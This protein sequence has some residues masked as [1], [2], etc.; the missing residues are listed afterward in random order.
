[1][2]RRRRYG[3][4]SPDV[5]ERGTRTRQQI[6]DSTLELLAKRGLHDTI[7]DD[8]AIG[9]GVSRATLYQYFESKDA[10]FLEMVDESGSELLRVVAELGVLGP[11]A[12]GYADLEGWLRSWASVYDKYATIFI[13]W[14][15][16]DVPNGQLRPRLVRFLEV[17]ISRLSERLT[18]AGVE[19][20]DPDAIAIALIAVIERCNYFRHTRR[21]PFRDDD[22]LENLAKV[23]QLVLFPDTPR[24][25]LAAS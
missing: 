1:L 8:I 16:V 10:L 11:T 20:V 6:I 13:Q 24:E 7:V 12:E 3:P 22:V 17:C 15:H 23:T 4:R 21:L 5:G 9:A 19:G 14:A 2:K 25:L 18:I